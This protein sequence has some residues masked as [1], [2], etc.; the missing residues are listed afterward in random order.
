MICKFYAVNE[1]DNP[2]SICDELDNSIPIYN[3]PLDC[4]L[5]ELKI[6]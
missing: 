3:C 6:N 1:T 4:P 5:F 2:D